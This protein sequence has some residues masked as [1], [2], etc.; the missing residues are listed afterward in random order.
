MKKLIELLKSK[1]SNKR[2][3]FSI[4]M[5]VLTLILVTALTAYMDILNQKWTLN[6]V[7]TVMDT[8]GIN[9]LQNQVNNAALRA[10][11]LSL[12][13]G[14][15]ISDQDYADRSKGTFTPSEQ[16]KYK[17]DM[18]IY[19]KS[20][21]EKQIKDRTNITEYEVERVDITFSYDDWGLGK[22]TKKLPQIT[23]D[24]VVR[25]RVEQS[26]VFDNS[27]GVRRTMYS[28]RNNANFTVTYN[29]KTDDG[30]TELIVRSVTRL[31]YR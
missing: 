28:A 23:L 9:T 19:Y 13:A 29:G 16:Q 3:A 18:A 30:Q 7:Q 27:I 8:A 20:E 12:D 17:S 31:V 25:M 5:V 15:N 10:E 1:T 24:A 4:L 14:N 2:G 26:G 11:I 21:L 6:E 22:T